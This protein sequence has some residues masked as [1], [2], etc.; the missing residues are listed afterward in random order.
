MWVGWR[1]KNGTWRATGIAAG[2]D[3]TLEDVAP[4]DETQRG[5]IV[6]RY[7]GTERMHRW[8][9]E[10]KMVHVPPDERPAGWPI[11]GGRQ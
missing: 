6:V 11:V 5:G 8:D 10:A 9:D 7:Y 2:D 4:P 1:D 3:L